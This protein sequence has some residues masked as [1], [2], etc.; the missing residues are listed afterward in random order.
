MK[1]T[2]GSSANASLE[3]DRFA[4]RTVKRAG[5]PSRAERPSYDVEMVI[6][7][8]VRVF[9]RRGYEASSMRDIARATG[10]SKSSLYYHVASKEELLA[11]ALERAFGPLLA[12]FDEPGATAGTPLARLR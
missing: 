8:A 1:R 6:D 7:A 11:R 12:V 3:A 2:A 10:L 9:N 5:R 4:R